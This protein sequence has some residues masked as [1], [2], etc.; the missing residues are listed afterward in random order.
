M[1]KIKKFFSG[2]LKNVWFGI[3]TSFLASKFYFLIKVSILFST[4]IIP[5]INIWIWKNVLNGILNSDSK[6]ESILVYLFIYLILK[7]VMYLINQLD[8][9]INTRYGEQMQFYIE[10]IMM[11]KTSRVDL[12]F[13]DSAQMGD[14]V[15]RARSNFGV[16]T[17]TTWN[18]FNMIFNLI[19]VVVALTIVCSYKYWLGLATLALLIPLMI[20]NKKR[21]D[22]KLEMEKQQIRDNRKIDYYKDVY[23]DNNVQFEIKLNNLGSYFVEKYKKTWKNLFVINEKENIKHNFINCMLSIINILSE[24]IVLIVS[25]IDK[26]NKNIGIGD[27]QYNFSM[28][29]RLRNQAQELMDN[30]NSFLNNSSRLTELQEFVNIKTEMEKTGLKLPSNNPKIEFCNVSF[31]YPNTEQFALKNCSFEIQPCKKIGLVGLNGSGK[32]TIIKMLFRFYDPEEGTIKLDGIDLREYNVYAV[33][34]VFSVLFQDYVTYCLPLREII[35][36]SDF[37]ARYNNE[38]LKKACEKSGAIDIV[39]NWEDGFDSVLGRYYADGGKDLSGG[40]W[41]LISLSRTYFKDSNY[42][43]LDEPSAALDPLFEDQIFK[44][45]YYNN[46]EKSS[47]AISHRLSNMTSADKIIV[48]E[49]GRVVEQGSHLELIKFNGKY[50]KLFNIQAARYSKK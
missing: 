35:A 11:E 50:A 39:N 12:A 9:Y 14:K 27:V 1:N 29:S 5:I 43:I 3:K 7:L 37:D 6:T 36:L 16:M 34:K 44:Q 45:L 23:L 41:Q 49:N 15:R 20:Y 26:I 32:S 17:Q 48:V 46:K 33:R 19:N 13:F 21:A 47:I 8:G 2:F 38:K 30:I 24:L 40:Q 10:T 22:K 18:I 42:V 28:V 25:M 4:T 31:R